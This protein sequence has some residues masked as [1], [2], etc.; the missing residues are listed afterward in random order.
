MLTKKEGN[1]IRSLKH[2]KYRE[3][4]GMFFVEGEKLVAELLNSEIE[5][6]TVYATSKWKMPPLRVKSG[7]DVRIISDVELQRISSLS[8]PNKVLCTAKIPQYQFDVKKISGLTLVL[9][10]IMD[11]G[12]LGT[13]IRTADWFGI[14]NILCSENC[15][16]LYNPKVVQS[17]MGSIL[18]VKVY[19]LDIKALLVQMK[20]SMSVF[21]MVLNGDSIYKRE[22]PNDVL[23]LLGNESKGISP[24][25]LPMVHEKLSIPAIGRAESLNAALACAIA[26]SEYAKKFH[27]KVN[28]T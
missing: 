28:D 18:R 5:V 21:G 4:Y 9:D 27:S 23:L 26:C 13:I 19:Y 16:D 10:N 11:P 8:T 15:V 6:V 14:E 12:N 1:F 7:L 22:F 24:E 17:T 20:N 2:K 25:L 3:R